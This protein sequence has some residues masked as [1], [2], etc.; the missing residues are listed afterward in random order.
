MAAYIGLLLRAAP[1]C[2][3]SAVIKLLAD[4]GSRPRRPRIVML[5]QLVGKAEFEARP[6]L[7]VGHPSFERGCSEQPFERAP[8]IAVT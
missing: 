7:V 4:I 6:A 8:K 1:V 3:R 5:F 2:L